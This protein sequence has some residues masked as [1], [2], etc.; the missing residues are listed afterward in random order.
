M[1]EDFAVIML[2]SNDSVGASEPP[3]NEP[4][5]V[6]EYEVNMR[7]LVADTIAAGT[8]KVILM[9]PPTRIDCVIQAIQGNP[10]CVDRLTGYKDAVM[11]ICGESSGDGVICGP[12]VQ[13]LTI[14]DPWVWFVA[15]STDVTHFSTTGHI[16]LAEA[17][18]ETLEENGLAEPITMCPL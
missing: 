13:A 6:S 5:P 11:E 7:G 2:G 4:T 12:D 3:N 15:S 8:P 14:A 18:Q 1:P 16:L 9:T 10:A 17:L